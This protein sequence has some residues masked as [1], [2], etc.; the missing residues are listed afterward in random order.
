M[1]AH[2]GVLGLVVVGLGIAPAVR[3][4]LLGV[5]QAS[6]CL[7]GPLLSFPVCIWVVMLMGVFVVLAMILMVGALGL[8]GA[9]RILRPNRKL[10]DLL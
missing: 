6:A 5:A 9:I 2:P 8:C 10:T 7:L 3:L 4:A 1:P